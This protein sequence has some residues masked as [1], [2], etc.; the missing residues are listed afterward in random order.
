MDNIFLSNKEVEKLTTKE[1]INYYSKLKKYCIIKE[2]HNIKSKIGHEIITQIYPFLRNY[3]Y[4]IIGIENIPDNGKAL[5]LCNHSNSHDFFTAHEVFKKIGSSVSVLCASDDLNIATEFLF[6]SCNAVL[7][8]RRNKSSI[9]KGICSFSTNLIE[10]MPGVI[11]GEGTWN[12][13]PYKPMQQIKIGASNI[14]AISEVPIIPTIFEYIEVPQICSKE[15]QLYSKCIVSFGHPIFIS[16]EENLIYQTKM[17]QITMEE[18]RLDLWKK[19]GIMRSTI[20]DI[21]QDI[22]LNHTYL[23]KFDALGFT[24]DSESESRFLFSKDNKPVENEF[25][26]DESGNFVPGVTYKKTL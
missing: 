22:Y 21:N 5:F 13:H 7:I 15:S 14:A 25:H 23:K 19:I 10:G 17:L 6:K 3:D 18:K 20:N 12:L 1:K 26:I 4:D 8:D 9:E 11:F 16:R 2:K 24:Y